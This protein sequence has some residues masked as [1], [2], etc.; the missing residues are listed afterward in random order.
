MPFEGNKNNTHQAL[1]V[2]AGSLSS[3]ALTIIS[4]AILSRYL[5]K[6]EYGT[7]RQI[8][9]I[10]TTFLLVFNAGLTKVFGFYL[11]RFSL[12][13]GR[14]IVWRISKILF[15]IGLIFSLA[16]YSM[17]GVIADILRNPELS[18]GLKYFSPIPMLLLPTLGIEGI[19]SS[20]RRPIYIAI[21]NLLSRSIMLLFIVIPVVVLDRTYIYAIYGWLVASILT[22]LLALFF[23]GIPFRG[24]TLKKANLT[25]T[26]IFSYSL[27][28]LAASLAGIAISSASQFY[29][30]RYFG[31]E[32]FAAY[33]NGFIQLPFALMIT[34]ATSTVLLPVF[35]KMV[36][37]GVH[38]TKV[39]SLW[40][41]ATKKSAMITY[42]MV[43]FFIINSVDVVEL[44]FSEKY[45]DS[46]IYFSIAMILNY[47]NIIV[48]TPLILAVGST[49]AYAWV[50]V[51]FAVIAWFS[52]YF[53]VIYWNSPIAVAV[54]SV[55]LG[56]VM[57][58]VFLK[59]SAYL[60]GSSVAEIM[61][62]KTLFMLLLH[63]YTVC[64]IMAV[65]VDYMLPS[66]N[67]LVSL[68]VCGLGSASALLISAKIFRLDYI[69]VI[70]PMLDSILYSI[71]KKSV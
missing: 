70:K 41:S 7:Y 62:F 34:A 63:S 27:P 67:Q 45:S 31:V 8:A 48:F 71:S 29:I 38:S 9:Y 58:S 19:F 3:I 42:P 30:S 47:F 35:S 46:A 22:F 53:V 26:E 11:P 24:L 20:Y 21:Y 4:A 52:Q 17:S 10:Y 13:E 36:F 18:T 43:T 49:K 5:D 68:I 65:T 33:S 39:I 59:Y 6:S 2:A 66:A 40:R 57:V 69:S 23:K 44:L 37:D 25:Y 32:V 50:H 12:S 55:L 61:P 28:L 64:S 60:M 14:S 54:T 56:V 51:V 15:L 16:L 1:W